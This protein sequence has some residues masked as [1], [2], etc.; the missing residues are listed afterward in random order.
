DYDHDILKPDRVHE[1]ILRAKGIE[2]NGHRFLVGTSYAGGSIPRDNVLAV[3]DFVLMHGNGV[4]DPKRITQMVETVRN[5]LGERKIPI[6][7]NEDDHFNFDKEANNMDATIRAGASWGYFDYR[8]NGE[9]FED[10]YQ[11][12]PVDWTINSE[13]KRAFFQHVK[14]WTV[15]GTQ[16]VA[17]DKERITRTVRFLSE[18]NHPR[19]ATKENKEKTVDYITKSIADTG[20]EVTRSEFARKVFLCDVDFP[21]SSPSRDHVAMEQF[22]FT[23]TN[24]HAMK[25]GKTNKRIVVGAHYDAVRESPGADDNA[26]GVAV[27]I[28]LAHL[29][30]NAELNCDVELVSYDIEEYGCLGSQYHAKKLKAKNVDVVC[31]LDMDLVGYY[32]DKENSQ[33]YPVSAMS[34]LY[35]TKGDFL[36]MIGRPEDAKLLT[37]ATKAFQGASTLRILSLPAPKALEGLLSR[38]DHSSF[39]R[40]GYPALFFTDTAEFRNK[41]YHKSTD[42]WDTLDYDRL[43][44]VPVGLYEIILMIDAANAPK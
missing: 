24:I 11:S 1:L 4:S 14:Q 38:S 2:R 25:K 10:G 16:K 23:F 3:S 39:W 35:G 31:M 44:Q 20:F 17:A 42:T 21:A 32:S 37:D 43:A 15:E 9:K 28:E 29:L 22:S 19:T 7:F 41:N 6:L 26:S 12:V 33:D 27:L 5:K 30:K 36:A 8:M 13:R 40:E 18:E 34:L